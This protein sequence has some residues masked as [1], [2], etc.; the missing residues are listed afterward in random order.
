[1]EGGGLLS[2][3]SEEQTGDTNV[4]QENKNAADFFYIL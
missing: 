1:M 2:V 4:M 3:S